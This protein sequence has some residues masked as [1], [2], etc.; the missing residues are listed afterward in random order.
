[1][2]SLINNKVQFQYMSDVV[3][4]SASISF[5]TDFKP[6]AVISLRANTATMASQG[7]AT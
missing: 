4:E 2:K 7:S 1:M 3:H 5:H 6:L